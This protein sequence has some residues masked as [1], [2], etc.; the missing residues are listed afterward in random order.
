VGAGFQILT[1]TKRRLASK[2]PRNLLVEC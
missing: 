2:L 1:S